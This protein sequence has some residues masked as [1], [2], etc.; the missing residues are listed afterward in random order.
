MIAAHPKLQTAIGQINS[1]LIIPVESVAEWA[2][3]IH[4]AEVV[5]L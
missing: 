4:G 2:L 5:S 3:D 1:L